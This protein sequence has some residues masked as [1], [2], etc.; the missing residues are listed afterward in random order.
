MR[1]PISDS[2]GYFD[3]PEKGVENSLNRRVPF[4]WIEWSARVD[5]PL[6]LLAVSGGYIPPHTVVDYALNSLASSSPKEVYDLV[7]LDYEEYPNWKYEQEAVAKIAARISEVEWRGAKKRLFYSL[8]YWEYVNRATF[9]WWRYDA[10]YNLNLLWKDFGRPYA[11]DLFVEQ[12][13]EIDEKKHQAFI[14]EHWD[15]CA[16]SSSNVG[17]DVIRA[18]SQ[19]DPKGEARISRRLIAE[20]IAYLLAGDSDPFLKQLRKQFHNSEIIDEQYTGVG[21]YVDFQVR[22]ESLR[23]E[24]YKQ[25][26]FF[27]DLEADIGSGMVGFI[28]YIDDGF[29]SSLEAY[30]VDGEG[31]PPKE[32][33]INYRY[34]GEEGIVFDSKERNWGKLRRQWDPN[35]AVCPCITQECL[36]CA[37]VSGENDASAKPNNAKPLEWVKT[38]IGFSGGSFFLG[39]VY[40]VY[41][42]C[43]T[44]AFILLAIYIVG[45]FALSV[46]MHMF[47]FILA[48]VRVFQFLCFAVVAYI[49]PRIYRN[50]YLK[51]V[52]RTVGK[53]SNDSS[54]TVEYVAQHGGVNAIAAIFA[55][56]VFVVAI[57]IS[58]IW[59]P[60]LLLGI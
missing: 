29:I 6:V 9:S 27:G 39:P 25:N 47:H 10:F 30:G 57:T 17:I 26:L 44:A 18:W 12:V 56:I 21:Y 60:E 22:D 20:P 37:F 41:R 43:Y 53:H 4:W 54:K 1:I 52:Q 58:A 5:W 45:T 40:W 2:S 23:I 13:Y 59:L 36:M 14:Q 19:E 33:F 38:G 24:G 48:A 32:P 16:P 49:F 11:D 55:F 31:W 51:I 7:I 15:E 42:K 3:I 35:A 50:R 8:V 46:F 34:Y 28:L